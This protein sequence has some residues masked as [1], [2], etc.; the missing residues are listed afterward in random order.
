MLS[1]CSVKAAALAPLRRLGGTD[2]LR[3]LAEALARPLRLAG[4]VQ[5]AERGSSRLES[6]Q[7]RRCAASL[8][9]REGFDGV[10]ALAERS[11]GGMDEAAAREVGP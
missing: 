3:S 2:H 5:L 6:G 11:L 9:D 1:I 7:R 8:C 10:L 4:L